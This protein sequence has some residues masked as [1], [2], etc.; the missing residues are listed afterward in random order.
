MI[1]FRKYFENHYRKETLVSLQARK[2]F[3]PVLLDLMETEIM[4]TL[5]KDLRSLIGV[6]VN[7]LIILMLSKYNINGRTI[8]EEKLLSEG[9]YGYILKA[10]DVNT[11][12]VFALKKSY[13]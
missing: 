9:G 2:G 10:I 12:E 4:Q 8:Q 3:I 13:C 1:N 5:M 11:R 6:N 7:D